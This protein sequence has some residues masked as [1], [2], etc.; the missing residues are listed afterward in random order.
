M[1]IMFFK[2]NKGHKVFFAVTATKKS[3]ETSIFKCKLGFSPCKPAA[4]VAFDF[5]QAFVYKRAFYVADYIRLK[6]Q[7]VVVIGFACIF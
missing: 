1:V 7:P 6:G 3:I 5:K 4:G 2:C